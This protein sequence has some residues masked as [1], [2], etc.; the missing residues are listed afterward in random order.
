MPQDSY[1]DINLNANIALSWYFEG[2]GGAV[3]YDWNTVIPT[4]DGFAITLP[5]ATLVSEGNYTTF[6]N[7]SA[8]SFQLKSFSGSTIITLTAGQAYQVTLRD[9]STSGGTWIPIASGG[10][11]SSITSVIAQS[12]DSS[13]NI[14]GGTLSPPGGT[15]NFQLPASMQNLNSVATTGL[16]AITA[17]APLTWATRTLLA[18]TN[19][20]I[21]NGNGVSNNPSLD[22]NP[23]M[24]N[25]TSVAVGNLQLSTGVITTTLTNGSVTL[26]SAGTGNVILNGINIDTSANITGINNLTVSGTFNNPTT[27]KI[28]VTFTDSLT[29]GP[30][31]T[32]VVQNSSGSSSVTGSAGIYVINFTT[33]LPNTNYG[34]FFGLGSTTGSSPAVTHAFW[35][36]K[37]TT[38]VT[39]AIVDASGVLVTE[40]PRGIS[41]MIMLAT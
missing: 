39:I 29:P 28:L 36:V 11:T 1:Q 21:T 5:K 17:T 31:H 30:S 2:T 18:G 33:A 22:V 35:T 40:V 14:T 26:S 16:V 24:T 9:N 13:I 6:Y 10:G 23:V 3:I 12:T 37:T 19:I 27:P 8:F 41:V 7:D 20:A 4:Q 38:S 34:V 15:I 25:L 32:L